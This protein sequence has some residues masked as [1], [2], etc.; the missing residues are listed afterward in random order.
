MPSAPRAASA[1]PGPRLWRDADF[2]GLWLGQTAS[3]LGAQAGQVT[4]PLIA[5]VTLDVGAGQLGALRAVEQAPV[6]IFSL[7]AGAWVDRRRARDVMVLAD[8]GR[9]LTLGAVPLAYVLGVLGVPALP[10]AP[11]RPSTSPAWV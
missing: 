8:L 1:R 5:V 10:G 9:A 2:R 4:L 11:W 7:V 6:L 3:Q